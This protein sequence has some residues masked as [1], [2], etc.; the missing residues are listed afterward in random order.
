MDPAR[1]EVWTG[2]EFVRGAPIPERLRHPDLPVTCVPWHAAVTYCAWTGGRLPTE[3]EWERAARGSYDRRRYPWVDAPPRC[4]LARSS[5]C[6]DGPA[7][8][9]THPA[10]QSPDGVYDLA[11]NVAEWVA[12]WYHP[13]AHRQNPSE[14]P[15]GPD[16]G[17]VRVVRGGSFYDPPSDLRASYR[18]GLTPAFGY[19]VVGFRCAR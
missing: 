18:Y 12:D 9:G 1:C 14:N 15:A 4:D 11:G 16:R 3:A 19:G 2:H 6:G 10:G 5:G 8:V 17:R 13:R 7:P